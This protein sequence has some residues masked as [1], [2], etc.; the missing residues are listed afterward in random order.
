MSIMDKV[1]VSGVAV[2]CAA[3]LVVRMLR[4]LGGDRLRP[5]FDAD[6][7]PETRVRRQFQRRRSDE[8][9]R[10]VEEARARQAKREG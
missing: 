5:P 8:Q 6:D 10:A 1:I 7:D 4:Q 3:V 2:L 9:R